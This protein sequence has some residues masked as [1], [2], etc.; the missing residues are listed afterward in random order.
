MPAVPLLNS[1]GAPPT[2]SSAWI[3]CGA[4][5]LPSDARMARETRRAATL[6]RDGRSRRRWSDT[7]WTSGGTHSPEPAS[8]T[9]LTHMYGHILAYTYTFPH[10]RMCIH[11]HTHTHTLMCISHMVFARRVPLFRPCSSLTS[12]WKEIPGD[13]MDIEIEVYI[14][15][16]SVDHMCSSW[17]FF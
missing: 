2:C 7:A 1:R 5:V 16:Q 4:Y 8:S 11:T 9:V 12:L 14:F 3:A 13:R 17:F 10:M 6:R 15:I